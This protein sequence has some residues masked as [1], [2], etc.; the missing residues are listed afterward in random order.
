MNNLKVNSYLFNNSKYDGSIKIKIEDADYIDFY[1]T[2]DGK[3]L[4]AEYFD[5]ILGLKN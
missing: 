4:V 1:P 2:I 3:D 5:T